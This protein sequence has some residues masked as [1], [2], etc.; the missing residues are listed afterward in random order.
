[1]GNPSQ[2]IVEFSKAIEL[3]PEFAKSYFGR[4]MSYKSLGDHEKESADLTM[5]RKLGIK[6]QQNVAEK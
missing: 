5:A 2:A 1:M 6:Q 4:A 3:D